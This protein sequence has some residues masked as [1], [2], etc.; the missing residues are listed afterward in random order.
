MKRWQAD[1]A[2][3]A[4][5]LLWGGAFVA[6]RDVE[7]VMPPLTFVAARF[8]ISAVALA[9]FAAFE[10]RRASRPHRCSS[11]S[12]ASSRSPATARS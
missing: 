7:S 8:A 12:T 2:L 11:R 3:L 10:A 5:A 9:P 4:T 6:Q 1:A